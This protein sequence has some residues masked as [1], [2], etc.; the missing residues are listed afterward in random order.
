[1]P[2]WSCGQTKRQPFCVPQSASSVVFAFDHSI[3]NRRHSACSIA[4]MRICFG[5][6]FIVHSLISRSV[7]LQSKSP[8]FAD[9][10][11][12]IVF[13]LHFVVDKNNWTTCLLILRAIVD[14]A[15]PC[16]LFKQ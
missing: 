12:N 10:E 15:A 5:S 16:R 4:N 2:P 3:Q 14:S 11:L 7:S 13:H 9:C 1:M 8:F 6:N